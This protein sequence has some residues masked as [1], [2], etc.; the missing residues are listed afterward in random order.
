[1]NLRRLLNVGDDMP[2][3]AGYHRFHA[4]PVAVEER[5]HATRYFV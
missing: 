1:M 3:M 5:M 4:V 2:K